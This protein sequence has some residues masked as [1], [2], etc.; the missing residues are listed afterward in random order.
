MVLLMTDREGEK[1]ERYVGSM[2]LDEEKCKALGRAKSILAVSL[3]PDDCEIIAGGYLAD[4]V[5]RGAGV[6]MVV[7]TDGKMG[8]LDSDRELPMGGDSRVEEGGTVGGGR[9]VGDKG[10][11]VLR[12]R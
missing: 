1:L 7:V 2:R 6:K 8:L 11:P 12:M 10:S 5:A 9:R 4:A 3:H